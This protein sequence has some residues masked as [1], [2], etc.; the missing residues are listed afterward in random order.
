MRCLRRPAPQGVLPG[1]ASCSRDRASTARTAATAGRRARTRSATGENGRR[2]GVVRESPSSSDSSSDLSRAKSGN[3]SA[4]TSRPPRSP[5]REHLVQVFR[6]EGRLTAMTAIPG[7]RP[8]APPEAGRGHR[9]IGGSG[10]YEFLDDAEEVKVEPR[11]ARPATRS[12]SAR[13]RGKRV[14]FLPRHGRTTGS[15]RTRSPTAPTCGRCASL[16]VRRVLAPSAVG[17]LTASYGPGTLV[18]PDQL[19]D[20][21]MG[22]EQTYYDRAPATSRSPTRTARP[23]ARHAIA[24]ARESGWSPAGSGRW[25]SSTARGSPPAP[26]RSGTRRRAGR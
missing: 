13:W 18:I 26:S 24:A 10:F 7:G 3:G 15:R 1:R 11:S 9:G 12:R 20:R 21:T 23:C 16:G 4:A 19:V 14:A 2:S 8:L 5:S 22:R 25:S 17:S 6:R